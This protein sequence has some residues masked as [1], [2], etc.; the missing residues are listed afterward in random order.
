[1]GTFVILLI[2]QGKG[3]TIKNAYGLFGSGYYGYPMGSYAAGGGGMVAIGNWFE[4]LAF[5]VTAHG[6]YSPDSSIGA[7]IDF[8][9]RGAILG[10]R[11]FRQTNG[12][13][14][15]LSFGLGVFALPGTF[16]EGFNFSK[17]KPDIILGLGFEW[18]LSPEISILGQVRYD[19]LSIITY[20]QN[21]ATGQLGFLIY[22]R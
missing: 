4:P 14:A 13:F 3:E 19:I 8:S 15:Y 5:L 21:V 9:I 11:K 12:N 17:V 6:I 20:K 7:A 18:A 1:M 2:S 16:V 10:Q 22:G